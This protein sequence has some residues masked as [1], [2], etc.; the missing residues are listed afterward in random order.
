MVGRLARG[1]PAQFA[2]FRSRQ[3]V[4]HPPIN[5]LQA[6]SRMMRWKM[7]GHCA[8]DCSTSFDNVMKTG[9]K[10]AARPIV[11]YDKLPLVQPARS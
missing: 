10:K 2:S 4:H 8:C 6:D 9:S 3:D 7:N 1:Q 11:V 5:E